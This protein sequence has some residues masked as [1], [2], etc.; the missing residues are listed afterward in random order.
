MSSVFLR[1]ASS[2]VEMDR[3]AGFTSSQCSPVMAMPA[4]SAA[5]RAAA[6]CAL[7]SRYGSSDSV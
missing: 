3:P 5:A 7:P 2:R 4:S 6:S 1:T